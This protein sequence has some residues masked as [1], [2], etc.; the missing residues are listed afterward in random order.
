MAP[1]RSITACLAGATEDYEAVI[2]AWDANVTRLADEERR[3]LDEE[4]R[5]AA[6]KNR[7]KR[8]Q[9]AINAF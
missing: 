2:C 5:K 8:I 9:D 1:G 6:E 4:A 3:A 7:D